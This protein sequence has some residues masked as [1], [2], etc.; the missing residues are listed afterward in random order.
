MSSWSFLISTG[1]NTNTSLV[2]YKYFLYSCSKQKRE[3]VIK[4]N[5]MLQWNSQ[6]KEENQIWSN[7][8]LYTTSSYLKKNS[9]R[10]LDKVIVTDPNIHL[11]YQTTT[12][13]N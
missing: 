13:S 12:I 10:I 4:Y 2:L 9:G 5:T 11:H 6:V 8:I 3:K 1:G 7:S